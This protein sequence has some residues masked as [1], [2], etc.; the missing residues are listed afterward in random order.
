MNIPLDEVIHFDVITSNPTTGA[1]AD[2]DS[3]PTF[4][5]YE[6]ATD[7]DIGVGGNLTKRTSLTGNYRGTFTLSAANGFEVGKWYSVI[8]SA[9]VSTVAGKAVARNFRVI[10]AEATAGFSP[11]ATGAITAAVVAT[12][13]IDADAISTDFSTEVVAAIQAQFGVGPY[14]S[15]AGPIDVNVTQIADNTVYGPPGTGG[16]TFPS[17]VASEASFTTVNTKLDTIDNFLDTEIQTLIDKLN[18]VIMGSGTIGAT[19]NDT[20]HVHIPSFTYGNDEI[21][22]CL[23]VI[24]DVSESEYHSTWV[25]D[26]VVA[27]KLVTTST[28]LPFTPQN[29]VDNYWLLSVRRDVTASV[30]A[31]D[32]RSAIGLASAN[33]DTQLSGIQADTDNIQTRIPTSLVS[34]RIDASVGA[35]AAD[36]VT[37]SAIAN[38]A[39]DAGAI[40]DNAITNAKI[41]DG[42]ITDAKITLPTEATGYATTFMTKLQQLYNRFFAK[43]TYNKSGLTIVTTKADGSTTATTQAVTTNATNDIVDKAT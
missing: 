35:M 42:A 9:T 21:N 34:G 28:T 2:A 1:A 12:G 30:G 15:E 6:E 13:A 31:S 10:A 3:T 11:L 43:T 36:T 32:I 17:V 24:L 14:T 40:A 38:N 25:D 5:V 20:N 19:G 7:T 29:S 37:A 4:A 27:S 8:A 16:I 41:A 18:G 33:L 39:I 22:N 26:W 23:L